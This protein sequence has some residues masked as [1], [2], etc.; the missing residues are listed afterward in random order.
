[1]ASYFEAGLNLAVKGLGG[2]CF[3]TFIADAL[4]DVADGDD[5]DF[6]ARYSGSHLDDH[7]VASD[8][9][10]PAAACEHHPG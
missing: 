9:N 7:D 3:D 4:V 8:A 6:L 2:K 10:D 1:M 5:F